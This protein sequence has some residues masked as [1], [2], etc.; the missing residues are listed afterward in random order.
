MGGRRRPRSRRLAHFEDG[1][2]CHGAVH[3][4]VQPVFAGVGKF[5][6]VFGLLIYEPLMLVDY[7]KDATKPWL[8]QNAKWNQDGTQLTIDL[9][10]G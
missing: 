4:P 9:R 2:R 7:V 1:C 3:I 10:P 6:R 8:A 5:E